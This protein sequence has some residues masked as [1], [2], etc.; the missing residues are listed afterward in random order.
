MLKSQSI[1]HRCFRSISFRRLSDQMD[2]KRLV[3]PKQINAISGTTFKSKW[4]E[5]RDPKGSDLTYYWNTETNETTALGASKPVTWIEVQD[6]NGSNATYWWAPEI[7][8][9]T[10]LGAPQPP[11]VPKYTIPS[12]FNRSNNSNIQGQGQQPVP[13]ASSMFAYFA[14]GGA[15][16]IGITVG[17][18]IMKSIF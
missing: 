2:N 8:Q 11:T 4:K 14:I 16:T 10:A 15:L 7:G 17:T 12:L 9:T 18:A 3:L 5:Q 1:V 13:L 6:P